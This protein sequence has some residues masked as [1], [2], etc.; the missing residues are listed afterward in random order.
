MTALP[1]ASPG[2]KLLR[3]LAGLVGLFF[4]FLGISFMAFPDTLAAGFSVQ[5]LHVWGLNAIRGDFGGLFLGLAFFCFLGTARGSSRWLGVPMIFLLLIICGRLVSLRPDGYTPAGIRSLVIEGVLLGLL[6]AA[7]LGGARKGEGPDVFKLSQFLNRKTL[8]GGAVAAALLG[9]LIF[10]QKTTGFALVRNLAEKNIGI[11]ALAGLPDGL[12]I[13]LC[14]SGSP[15]P[16]HRRASACTAVLAGQDLFLV[17]AGPGSERKL[18]VMKL[19]P[20]RISAVFLTHFHSDHIGD[21][22]EVM[23]KRWSGGSR[24]TPLEVIGPAGVERVVAG[25][26]EAYALDAEYRIHHHGPNVVPPGGAGSRARVFHFSEGKEETV[27]L[28]KDGLRVTAFAVDHTPVRPAVGYRF[29][30]KG[31]S[32]VISGDTRSTQVTVRQAQGVDLLAHEALQPVM[33]QLLEETAQKKGRPNL[34][35]IMGDIP[36]YHTSPEEAARM[37]AQAGVRHLLLTHIVPPL[38]VA[39]L[40]PLFLG[41]AGEYFKGPITIGEDGLLVSLPA[42][43]RKIFQRPLL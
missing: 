26:N 12:H 16:D 34:A 32:L 14:G 24:T 42:G 19:N 20:G 28:E 40:K 43:N 36:Q 30:Y 23:L 35:R 2:E 15:L 10:S 21:L 41:R 31:R 29:D 39:D 27:V 11:D 4:L 6:L 13:A 3:L 25:F 22:G 33:V 17:D 37:A 1:P 9:L 38:P 18:E 8:A 7:A 5:P